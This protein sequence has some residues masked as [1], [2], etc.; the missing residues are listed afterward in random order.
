MQKLDR[1]LH[2]LYLV[3]SERIRPGTDDK[4]LVSWNALMMMAYAE[5]GRYLDRADYIEI[6]IRNADF[7]LNELIVDGRLQ[8]S[9]RAGN[10]RQDAFLE[11]YAA[12]SLGLVSLYQ[13]DPNPRWYQAACQLMEQSIAHFLNPQGGFFDTR[14]DHEA[15][16]IRPV[17]FQDNATPSGNSLAAISLILLSALSGNQDWV[18]LSQQMLASMQEIVVQ[19]PTAFANWLIALDL[20]AGPLREVAIIGDLF[21]QRTQALVNA[22]ANHQPHLSWLNPVY[23]PKPAQYHCWKIAPC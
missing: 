18:D 23:L 5:A 8:R 15:L 6:A 19:H 22:M 14:D 7:I 4:I 16:I 2:Q 11:D 17:D 10:A 12:L 13:S 1:M 21:D 3:R 9:W 20:A